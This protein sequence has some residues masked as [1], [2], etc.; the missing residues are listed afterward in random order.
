MKTEIHVQDQ[1]KELVLSAQSSN[2]RS[3]SNSSSLEHHVAK[4]INFFA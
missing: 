3:E 2:F 4:Y 1:I